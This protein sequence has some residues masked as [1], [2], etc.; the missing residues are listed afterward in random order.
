VL[1]YSLMVGS[2]V[3]QSPRRKPSE[4]RAAAKPAAPQPSSEP[5]ALPTTAA[6]VRPLADIAV[7]NGQMITTADIDPQV[8]GAVDALDQRIADARRQ[9]LNLEINT[10]LLDVEANKRKLTSQQLYDL[11]VGKKVTDPT[12]AEI[13]TFIE[14]NPDELETDD[15]ARLR[16]EVVAILRAERE[17]K[18]SD[19]FARRLR[20]A[21]S[22]TMGVDINAS[23]LQPGAVVATVSGRNI[24]AGAVLERLKPVI[25]RLRSIT[26]QVEKQ[27]LDRTIDDML[28]L[29]EANRR[30]IPPEE[31]VRTEISEKIHR[32]TSAEVD[33]FYA[34]N[35][36]NV[37]GQLNSVRHQL[38]SYLENQDQE[39]LERA[40]SE[41]L[42]KG[43]DVRF[44][45]SEPEPP[46]Q[47]IGT[48][49]DP[50]RGDANAPVTIVEFSDFECPACALMHPIVEQVVNS[51]GNKVRYVMRDYPLSRHA[52]ARKAA[53]AANAANAQGKFFEYAALLFKRQ[54]ALDVPSLKKY[55]SELGIDRTKFDAALDGGQYAAEVK[56]DI[57]DGE[58]YGVDSTPTIFVNGARLALLSADG[59]RTAIDRALSAANAGAKAPSN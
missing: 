52:H 18:L 55:A 26:Y 35:K 59:L 51:F 44:L 42:R 9:V 48:D 49:D 3:A 2:V 13:K 30:N 34:E 46:I 40:L 36:A 50:S 39:R 20:T 11:E 10:V 7:V 5:I 43:A 33:K 4:R 47:N 38:S 58:I 32:P 23:N 24:T 57:D 14:A 31:I 21:H 12:E 25:Y 45:L 22:V 53:E 8:R 54:K 19:E 16:S 37:A 15:P 56:H 28:L 29:S 6:P 41:R 1:I 17:Q 27:A